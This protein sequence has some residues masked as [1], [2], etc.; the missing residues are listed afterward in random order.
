MHLQLCSSIQSALMRSYS[1]IWNEL[2]VNHPVGFPEAQ[3]S[4]LSCGIP[5]QI[6]TILLL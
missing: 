5:K 6:G 4:L 1:L 2:L 3:S